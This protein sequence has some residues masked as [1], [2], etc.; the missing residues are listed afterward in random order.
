MPTPIAALDTSCVS[1]IPPRTAKAAKIAPDGCLA[2]ILLRGFVDPS[3]V[4][5]APGAGDLD[6]GLL[7]QRRD[8]APDGVLLP[9]CGIHDLL[10]RGAAGAAQQVAHDRFLAELAGHPRRA[11]VRG[12]RGRGGRGR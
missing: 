12:G 10:Q 9:A 3:P 5:L 6:P 2:A 8:E 7:R 1:T 11:G 4:A